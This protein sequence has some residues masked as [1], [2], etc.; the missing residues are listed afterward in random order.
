MPCL[1][2][3]LPMPECPT[4]LSMVIGMGKTVF[5][6]V[7]NSSVGVPTKLASYIKRTPLLDG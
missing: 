4:T 1:M 2:K 7:S 3:K 6:G 5:I